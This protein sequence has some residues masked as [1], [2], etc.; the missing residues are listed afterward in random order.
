[1]SYDAF[2]KVVSYSHGLLNWMFGRLALSMRYILWFVINN[3][4]SGIWYIS[5]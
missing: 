5:F 2:M 3:I 4:P 1:M